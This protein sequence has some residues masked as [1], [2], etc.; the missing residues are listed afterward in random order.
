[1]KAIRKRKKS[2]QLA[3]SWRDRDGQRRRAVRLPQPEGVCFY[4]I[5]AGI[6]AADDRNPTSR[7]E[8]SHIWPGLTV[9]DTLGTASPIGS[10]G[11]DANPFVASDI[12]VM[13]KARLPNT[14]PRR[15]AEVGERSPVK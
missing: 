1:M 10:R 11:R 12:A 6:C 9:K 13:Q 2:N 4:L 15:R 7:E 8:N 14:S 5:L 3:V